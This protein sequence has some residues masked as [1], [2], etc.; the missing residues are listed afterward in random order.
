M[1]FEI[2]SLRNDLTPVTKA[3]EELLYTL[4]CRLTS[5]KTLCYK[6]MPKNGLGVEPT[7]T[8][9][10][11]QH[12]CAIRD[13]IIMPNEHQKRGYAWILLLA[14][15]TMLVL[16]SSYAEAKRK[17]RNVIRIKDAVKIVGKIQKP[18]AFYVL[19]RAPLNYQGLQLKANFLKK[20]IQAVKK[21]PF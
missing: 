5:A 13:S 19:H 7:C 16:P 10:A 12:R 14:F 1:I 15:V 11:H 21:A 6:S 17:P 2:I 8:R 4:I 9:I 20:V 18:Q 3:L